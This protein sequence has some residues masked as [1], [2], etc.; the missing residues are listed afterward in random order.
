VFERFTERARQV[1]VLAQNE[2]RSLRHNYIGTEH[3]LLGLLREEEGLAARV[4]ESLDITAE[5]V[6]AQV[7]RIVG[8]GE[9]VS[10]GQIP[11]TPRAKKV[12]ELSLR[13]ALSLG[14]NYIGTEHV[15]LGLA[16]E[17]EGVAARILLDFGADDERIRNEVISL[18]SGPG[19]REESQTPWGGAVSRL[20]RAWEYRVERWPEAD[21]VKRAAELGVLGAF[22]W[23][24]AGVLQGKDDAEWIFQRPAAY[25]PGPPPAWTAALIG[26]SGYRPATVAD[27]ELAAVK[28]REVAEE[29][30]DTERV[31]AVT[32]F[33][34]RLEHAVVRA[35]EV[36]KGRVE[37]SETTTLDDLVDAL[38]SAKENAIE[39]GELPYASTLR[40]VE[41][42]FGAVLRAIPGALRGSDAA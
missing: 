8:Q 35:T 14:H 23:Q 29:A 25:R 26:E 6:R 13:E 33:E 42:E 39:R 18:I 22:G 1:V 30:G 37:V 19:R 4:L 24:L 41:R 16:R 21:Q 2:A 27:V 34:Q 36:L 7:A 38:R 10:S 31:A 15:L 12:L 11:F 28:A 40:N 3:I 17:N 9:D 20:T 32:E 5:E